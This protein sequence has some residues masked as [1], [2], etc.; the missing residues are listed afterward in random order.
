MFGRTHHQNSRR[1]GLFHRR[2]KDRMAGGYSE[3]L[4]DFNGPHRR[5]LRYQR[6]RSATQTPP[7]TAESVPKWS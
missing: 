6:L 1:G 7:V 5:L 3:F 4:I 2:D